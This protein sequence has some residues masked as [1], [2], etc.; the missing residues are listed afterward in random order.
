VRG[1]LHTARQIQRGGQAWPG[2]SFAESRSSPLQQ[3]IQRW[4]PAVDARWLVGALSGAAVLLLCGQALGLWWRSPPRFPDGGQLPAL[5]VP[6]RLAQ[7]RPNPPSTPTIPG[8]TLNQPVPVPGFGN[9]YWLKSPALSADL[10]SIVYVTYSGEQT[11]DDLFIAERSDIARPFQNHRPIAATLAPGRAAHPALS[12]DGL[13]LIY[14]E[15]GAPGKLWHARR[16][17]RKSEFAAP[18]EL[19]VSG[20]DVSGQ[21]CDAPQFL[22]P[23]LI[24]FAVGDVEFHERR[25][26]YARRSSA[27]RPFQITGQ[28]AIAN[29]WPR[30]FVA[31]GGRRAYFAAPDGINITALFPRS[32]QFVPPEPLLAPAILGADCHDHDDMLWVAPK[33]DVIFYCSGGVP[34]DGKNRRLWMVRF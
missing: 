1:L 7:L 28:M 4:L 20:L 22:E 29:G 23:H 18:V 11:L 10:L 31:G 19:K 25:Q 8:L 12:P 24:R 5:N 30:Y 21:H 26:V 15:L 16:T 3:I 33:E 9:V 32:Q 17:S 34:P 6:S 27:S 2:S 13:E 14:A